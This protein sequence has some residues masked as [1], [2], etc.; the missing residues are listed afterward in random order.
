VDGGPCSQSVVALT[1]D[2]P[3][4]PVE[5]RNHLEV[6]VSHIYDPATSPVCM[7]SQHGASLAESLGDGAHHHYRH[8]TVAAVSSNICFPI[9]E[10]SMTVRVPR[11]TLSRKGHCKNN[12]QGHPA[13]AE[14]Q[15]LKDELR[16]A[17]LLPARRDNFS[18]AC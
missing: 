3:K 15:L 18:C 12:G 16:L 7:R 10:G 9:R 17:G 14:L 11:R 1:L 5:H 13:N 4:R 8:Q 2:S 6:L